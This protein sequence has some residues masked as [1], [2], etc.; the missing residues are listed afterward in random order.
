MPK[1]RAIE[2]A[3]RAILDM[4]ESPEKYD[5]K[6][7]LAPFL[8][9]RSNHVV[10]AAVATAERL[11]AST[12]AQDMVDCFTNLMHDPAKRD[13]GCKALLAIAKA[14]ASMDQSAAR[15][16]FLGIKH[17]QMEASFGPPV[18]AAAELRGVCAQGLARMLHP[19][20]LQ[21]CV[22]LLA[23]PEPAARAGAV[24]AIADYG[25]PEGA[26]L[27]RLK[28]LVGDKHEQ[29]IAECFSALLRLAPAPSLEFV[30]GFLRNPSDEIAQNA[31][32]ALGESHLAGAFPLLR[33]AW[34]QTAAPERRRAFLVAIALL[35]LDT[36][37]D[38]LLAR[39]SDDSL[40]AAAGAIAALGMYASDE[41]ICARVRP[42]VA[43]R[44]QLSSIFE[45]EFQR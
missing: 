14:L 6:R 28:A 4:R 16:Y 23:D 2:D 8:K 32:F 27:L 5:L 31:A 43:T 42:L 20:A 3:L 29:V 34:E 37:V 11:E 9:H 24:R 10:A 7:D 22:T 19:D 45:K 17:V 36:A 33:E 1:A 38:F 26:L 40:S 12:L 25:A 41:N 21:E 15:V 18:D 35:R 30:A 13:P 39:A 44:P